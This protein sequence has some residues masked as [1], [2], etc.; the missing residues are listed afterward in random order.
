M[1]RQDLIK[2]YADYGLTA[3]EISKELD[4]PIF[5]IKS[6][7][8]KPT[9]KITERKVKQLRC[10][11]PKYDKEKATDVTRPM[12]EIL[13]KY[14][15]RKIN[16]FI[17]KV[18]Y[19]LTSEVFGCKKGDLIALKLHFGYYNPIPGNA[20]DT[21][22]YF[23]DKLRR[24]VDK[25]DNRHCIRCGRPINDK[26]IRYHKISQ[27]GPMETDNCATLCLYCR[28]FRILKHYDADPERFRGMRF[29]EFREWIYKNDPF[30]HRN[31]V[32]PKGKIGTW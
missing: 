25:R 16:K 2:Q 15:P 21:I 11:V 12:Y 17:N 30:H 9:K 5:L 26:N 22:T 4:L 1:N 23:S 32:Y 27:P 14:G 18:G 3:E 8:I 28:S 6:A 31:R 24:K 7:L 10:S 13:Y 19:E 20:L 29:K